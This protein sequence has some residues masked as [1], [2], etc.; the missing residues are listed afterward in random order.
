ML[1]A[2][3]ANRGDISCENM[4]APGEFFQSYHWPVFSAKQNDS[5]SEEINVIVLDE[6]KEE[7]RHVP[8]QEADIR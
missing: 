3:S 1:R 7:N 2:I 5:Q 4:A 8:V 6:F